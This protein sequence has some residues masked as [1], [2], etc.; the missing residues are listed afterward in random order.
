MT[1]KYFESHFDLTAC[2]YYNRKEEVSQNIF[3]YRK[4]V[5]LSITGSSPKKFD[6]IFILMNPGSAASVNEGGILKK[7]KEKGY[8]EV[9]LPIDAD[10]TIKVIA[11]LMEKMDYDKV[12][13]INLSDQRAS[14]SEE[15]L[16]GIQN[17]GD[18]IEAEELKASIFHPLRK[19]DL[20]QYFIKNV[21]II[22][23]W[24]VDQRLS[25]LSELCIDCLDPKMVFGL[26]KANSSTQYYHP[27]RRP[28]TSGDKRK[29]E[30]WVEAIAG[31]LNRKLKR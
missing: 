18:S 12:R 8:F 14:R 5:D 23:G 30:S 3:P 6:A 27:L 11:S 24:G 28:I 26:Q 22:L 4:Y 29:Q 2:F 10:P 9:I 19:K 25:R 15:F 1:K 17:A 13:I 31:Q 20:K 16:K 21:P 7:T